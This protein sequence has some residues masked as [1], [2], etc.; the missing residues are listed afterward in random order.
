MNGQGRDTYSP[1][2]PT[3]TAEEA[4]ERFESRKRRRDDPGESRDD[5]GQ[6]SE[7][8]SPPPKAPQPLSCLYSKFDDN[9]Y[10]DCVDSKF[11]T[12]SHIKQHLND[13]HTPAHY[14][15]KCFAIFDNEVTLDVIHSCCERHSAAKLD[16]I[17]Y[18]RNQR[19]EQVSTGTTEKQWYMMWN[20][21][22]SEKPAPQNIYTCVDQSEDLTQN[23][24]ATFLYECLRASEGILQ[25]DAPEDEVREILS[26]GLIRVF[27][28]LQ[29]SQGSVF[30]ASTSQSAPNNSN[31]GV[32]IHRHLH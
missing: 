26:K 28:Q 10:R 4:V 11:T 6:Q 31:M 13:T 2:P 15:V 1:N 5:Q 22:F 18:S 8:R 24:A 14:C 3:V 30:D 16:G 7:L 20:I 29:S 27:E 19:L 23:D 32:G 21:L 9:E 12:I 25:A 17:S